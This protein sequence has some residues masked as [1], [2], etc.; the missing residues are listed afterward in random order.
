MPVRRE[1]SHM[2]EPVPIDVRI[3][4]GVRILHTGHQ[5]A[6]P[7]TPEIP[8]H[9]KIDDVRKV[10]RQEI[11]WLRDEDLAAVWLHGHLRA[12]ERADQSGP[13]SRGVH[14][15]IG[16]PAPVARLDA[17]HAP[18]ANVDG[19]DLH[20]LADADALLARALRVSHC[21]LVRRGPPIGRVV[22]EGSEVVDVH[23]R[24]ELLRFGC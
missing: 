1:R 24:H 22:R 8:T 20:A 9:V 16:A 19:R 7:L 21:R 5:D 15:H 6:C 14:D 2:R 23:A 12:R 18:A 17:V 4:A 13:R 10:A 11:E 3:E